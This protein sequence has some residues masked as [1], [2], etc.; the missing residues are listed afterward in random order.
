M[1]AHP[2]S[3]REW[4]GFSALGCGCVQTLDWGWTH[5]RVCEESRRPG[6][7]SAGCTSADHTRGSI[8]ARR[9]IARGRSSSPATR[10]WSP[11]TTN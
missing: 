11:A 8:W 7:R 10:S 9:R 4:L 5:Q 2:F 3:R 6:R 1:L